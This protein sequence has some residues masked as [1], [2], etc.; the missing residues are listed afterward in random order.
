MS[1]EAVKNPA[2]EV[3]PIPFTK[4]DIEKRMSIIGDICEKA[5]MIYKEMDREMPREMASAYA[6]VYNDMNWRLVLA[7]R[8]LMFYS[9]SVDSKMD[10]I[11]PGQ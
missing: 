9:T 6:M 7:C 4:A 1:H 8:D 2:H 5:E 3:K 10:A 11:L